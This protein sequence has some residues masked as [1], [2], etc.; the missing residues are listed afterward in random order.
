MQRTTIRYRRQSPVLDEP[1]TGN[2]TLAWWHLLYGNR[3]GST[4]KR[5]SRLV[6]ADESD[7]LLCDGFKS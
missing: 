6:D 2:A 4:R 1:F 3:D 7:R 5:P